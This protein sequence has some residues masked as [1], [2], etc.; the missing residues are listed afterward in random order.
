MVAIWGKRGGM[1]LTSLPYYL[2]G[3]SA[4]DCLEFDSPG[5]HV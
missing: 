4:E 3:A 1:G 2:F 5:L